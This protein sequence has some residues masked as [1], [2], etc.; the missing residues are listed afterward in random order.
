MGSLLDQL[1]DAQG[2]EQEI[3]TGRNDEDDYAEVVD[4][5][6]SKARTAC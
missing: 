2:K 4:W 6:V 3:G 5:R 1:Q